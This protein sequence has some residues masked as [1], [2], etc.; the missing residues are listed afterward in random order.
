[1]ANLRVEEGVSSQ[2]YGKNTVSFPGMIIPFAGE[3]APDGWILCNGTPFLSSQYPELSELFNVQNITEY[4]SNIEYVEGIIYAGGSSPFLGKSL[5]FTVLDASGFSQGDYVS[6][7]DSS[8]TDL[9]TEVALILSENFNS[10]TLYYFRD[11]S[12]PGGFATPGGTITKVKAGQVPNLIEKYLL[13]VTSSESLKTTGG[14][15]GHSHTA[16][17]ATSGSSNSDTLNH[18]HGANYSGTDAQNTYHEHT[19]YFNSSIYGGSTFGN[20]VFGNQG[21]MTATDHSHNGGNYAFYYG[22]NGNGAHAH[23]FNSVVS[24]NTNPSHSHVFNPSSNQSTVG[25]TAS[26]VL[27]LTKYINFI[28]KAG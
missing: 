14:N 15:V 21:N 9:N 7:T 20:F 12:L 17:Y 23:G 11:V 10:I 26:S 2:T 1:V 24:N 3:D 18:G 4:S 28:I 22:S 25:S 8:L 19:G 16:S 6:V 13:G 5:S 27:P